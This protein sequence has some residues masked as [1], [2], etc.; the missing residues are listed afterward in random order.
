[1]STVT[2]ITIDEFGQIMLP[3]EVNQELNL[4]NNDWL[5]VN[6]RPD[7]IVMVP[8]RDALDTELLD[9]L[10]REGILIDPQ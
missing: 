2:S 9:E 4:Q 5:K 3:L 6:I 10:I 8:S 1:M 7:C